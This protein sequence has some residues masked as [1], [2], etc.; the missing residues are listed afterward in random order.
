M[1]CT[2]CALLSLI[3]SL[4]PPAGAVTGQEYYY[5]D[6]DSEI[7]GITGTAWR[8]QAARGGSPRRSVISPTGSQ[9]HGASHDHPGSLPP[10]QEGS[11][12]AGTRATQLAPTALLPPE[13]K[14]ERWFRP[15]RWHRAQVHNTEVCALMDPFLQQTL[16]ATASQVRVTVATALALEYI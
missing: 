5:D 14:V 4:N 3:A 2:R 8:P 9:V 7:P 15:F 10:S 6:S 1:P 12:V 16:V 13:L 11:T